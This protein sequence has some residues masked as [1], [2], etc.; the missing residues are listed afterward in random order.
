MLP[1]PP[2]PCQRDPRHQTRNQNIILPKSSRLRKPWVLQELNL[3]SQSVG[4]LTYY[5]I[6]KQCIVV[7]DGDIIPPY[8]TM[9]IIPQLYIRTNRRE[10]STFTQPFQPI[11]VFF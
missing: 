9:G 11:H 2:P 8:D 5:T 7:S 10:T 3:L 1:R 4:A 6:I